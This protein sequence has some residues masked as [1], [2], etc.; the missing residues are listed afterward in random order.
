[1]LAVHVTPANAQG[2]AQVG[3]L[4]ATIKEVTG[5]RVDIAF[6]D[7]GDTG[8][9][10]AAA[11]EAHGIRREVVRLPAAK[12]GFVLLPRCWVV[13]RS[14]AWVARFRRLAR[15]YDRLQATLEGV[16]YLAFALLALTATLPILAVL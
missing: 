5:E 3:A 16:H 13:E 1:M 9:C 10:P 8:D 14:F 7:Q 2:R 15:D 6:V 4:A 11:A 12:R